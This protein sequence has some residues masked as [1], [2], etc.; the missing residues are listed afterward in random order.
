[1]RCFDKPVNLRGNSETYEFEQFVIQ[2]EY[3]DETKPELNCQSR[4]SA[5]S[6]M[7]GK[8]V[9][10]LANNRV[11]EKVNKQELS[12][13]IPKDETSETD[14]RTDPEEDVDVVADYKISSS[15]QLHW[16]LFNPNIETASRL[17]L[18]RSD[19]LSV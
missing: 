15:S 6:L 9:V 12:L 14:E 1:M 17:Q 18:S 2:F 7:K 16:S 5:M 13:I 4:T 10:I 11:I 19:A 8:S 3:C